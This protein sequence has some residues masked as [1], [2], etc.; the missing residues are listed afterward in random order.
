MTSTSLDKEISVTEQEL[1]KR[2]LGWIRR[3][4]TEIREFFLHNHI[5]WEVQSIIRNNERLSKTPSQFFEW[6]VEQ[7]VYS[8]TMFVRRQADK[9]KR[10]VS[11]YKL[12]ENIRSHP[13]VLTRERFLKA[14]G[15]DE[16]HFLES[17]TKN[18][19]MN[20]LMRRLAKA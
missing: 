13:N 16:N 5:F 12:L 6:M 18:K 9:T 4:D 15:Y 3:I 10:T 1:L 17:G 7:F 11:L 14:W 20:C 19:E 8:S 2:W